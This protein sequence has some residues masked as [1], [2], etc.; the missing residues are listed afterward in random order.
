ME[1]GSEVLGREHYSW[2]M[3]HSDQDWTLVNAP[4]AKY[5]IIYVLCRQYFKILVNRSIKNFI[6]IAHSPNYSNHTITRL[7][8]LT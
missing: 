3:F 4:L 5:T 2:Y 6:Q 1:H 8:S 7:N